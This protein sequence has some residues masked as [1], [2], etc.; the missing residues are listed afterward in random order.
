MDCFL[1]SELPGSADEDVLGPKTSRTL[2]ST[3]FALREYPTY[4][5]SALSLEIYLNDTGKPV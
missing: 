1:Y 2:S 3:V 5:T 4:N